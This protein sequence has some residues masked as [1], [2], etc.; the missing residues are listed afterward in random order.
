MVRLVLLARHC[1]CGVPPLV[2][3]SPLIN[4]VWASPSAW[5]PSHI[6]HTS[7]ASIP[8]A[9][10]TTTVVEEEHREHCCPSTAPSHP[11]LLPAG[12]SRAAQ[13]GDASSSVCPQAEFWC[14]SYFNPVVTHGCTL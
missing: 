3:L 1:R 13:H 4:S 11:A 5:L 8:G 14:R 10:H 7:M 9:A 12:Q 6:T 2:T